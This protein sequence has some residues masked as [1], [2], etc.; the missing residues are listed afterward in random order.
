VAAAVSWSSSSPRGR[1]VRQHRIRHK[2]HRLWSPH[3]FLPLDPGRLPLDPA[4]ACSSSMGSTSLLAAGASNSAGSL[5]LLGVLDLGSDASVR[6]VFCPTRRRLGG[7]PT[8]CLF[9]VLQFQPWWLLTRPA[10]SPLW[11]STACCPQDAPPPLLVWPRPR[12]PLSQLSWCYHLLL[13]L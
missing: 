13:L 3:L 7:P 8:R 1:G 9:C 2:G 10:S 4:D 12:P 5:G 11:S 6:M